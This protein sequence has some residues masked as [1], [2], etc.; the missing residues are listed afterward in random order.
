M[1]LVVRLDG[2]DGWCVTA[3]VDRGWCVDVDG[4]V[5]RVRGRELEKLS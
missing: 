3:S 1:S 2:M 5:M 4:G